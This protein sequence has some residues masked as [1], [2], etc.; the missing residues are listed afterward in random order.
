MAISALFRRQTPLN[1]QISTHMKAE[2]SP[3]FPKI[4]N[5]FQFFTLIS[6][7]RNAK[8]RLFD[9]V[10]YRSQLAIIL[11]ILSFFFGKKVLEGPRLQ[12]IISFV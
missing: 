5:F 9:T 12:D 7:L 8:K 4:Q 3:E 11:I 6:G 1:F 2:I 10:S